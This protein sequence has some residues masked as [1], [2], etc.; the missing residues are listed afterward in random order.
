VVQGAKD[1]LA[2]TLGRGLTKYVAGKIPFGQTSTI[3]QGAMQIAI[4][5][6]L[7]MVVKKVTRS[8]RAG[9]MFLA[10]AYSNVLQTALAGVPVIGA[11]LSGVSSW[12]R[13]PA[14]VSAWPKALP[15][16]A[17]STPSNA[18]LGQPWGFD[19]P[20]LSDGIMS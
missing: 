8:D 1:G 20:N 2:V 7:A 19:S 4:G 11:S 18:A 14:T 9:A 12:P 16:A 13:V 15:A 3:G 10:G 17:V 5:T 6:A